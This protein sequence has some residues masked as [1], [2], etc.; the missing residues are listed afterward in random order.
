MRSAQLSLFP[1]WVRLL[2]LRALI[3]MPASTI[4]GDSQLGSK[5]T[6]PICKKRTPKKKIQEPQWQMDVTGRARRARA[7][8]LTFASCWGAFH[9]AGETINQSGQD[10][11]LPE[12]HP[13]SFPVFRLR[14]YLA[15]STRSHLNSEVKPQRARQ[16]PW[17]GT[18]RENLRVL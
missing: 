10:F 2:L 16:V 15:E 8:P 17:W 3:R 14:P 5:N 6:R 13:W 7:F 9:K 1:A 11:D 18:A 4:A 12:P